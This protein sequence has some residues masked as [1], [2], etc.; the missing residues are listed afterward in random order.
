MP[1]CEPAPP[2]RLWKDAAWLAVVAKRSPALV[3]PGASF[4]STATFILKTALPWYQRVFGARASDILLLPR[5]CER[6]GAT[7]P[8]RKNRLVGF[9]LILEWVGRLK[10][11]LAPDWDASM[12]GR[13]LSGGGEK[14]EAVDSASYPHES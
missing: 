11:T 14:G 13:R 4:A 3:L 2:A 8:G 7:A 9:V 12:V 10:R 5:D 6:V 1:A